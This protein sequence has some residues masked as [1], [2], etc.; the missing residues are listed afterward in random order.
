MWGLSF[1]RGCR[2]GCRNCT[3][4][5]AH[6]VVIFFLVS[7]VLLLIRRRFG[8]FCSEESFYDQH[9]T[10]R[11]F[12]PRCF[13]PS[14]VQICLVICFVCTVSNRLPSFLF[15]FHS[16]SFHL[17]LCFLT[18]SV[19]CVSLFL[20]PV[21]WVTASFLSLQHSHNPIIRARIDCISNWDGYGIYW[22]SS[23]QNTPQQL[24]KAKLVYTGHHFVDV[25]DRS[26]SLIALLFGNCGMLPHALISF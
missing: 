13:S 18:H 8:C 23:R 24:L 6:V 25:V 26:W 9:W 12:V 14:P 10:F 1:V 11:P 19:V 7:S 5:L 22:N 4:M 21:L 15:L 2:F 3:T 16:L 20:P 17:P